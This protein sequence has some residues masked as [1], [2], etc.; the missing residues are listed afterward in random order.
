VWWVH[1]LES[2]NH[3]QQCDQESVHA[4]FLFLQL[5]L[6]RVKRNFLFWTGEL[7]LKPCQDSCHAGP[8]RELLSIAIGWDTLYGAEAADLP[9]Q[10]QTQVLMH[11]GLMERT[12]L[13]HSVAACF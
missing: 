7:V 8:G 6:E 1:L 3:G 10:V 11:H 4:S 2:K 12:S 9:Q 13:P 5:T